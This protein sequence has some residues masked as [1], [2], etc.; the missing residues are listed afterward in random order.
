M[1]SQCHWQYDAACVDLGAESKTE[2]E[3]KYNSKGH[4]IEKNNK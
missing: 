3:H 1:S 4:K 2:N